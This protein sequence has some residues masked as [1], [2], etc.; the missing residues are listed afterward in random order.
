[1]FSAPH[2]QAPASTLS[3]HDALPICSNYTFTV[4]NTDCYGCH[5]AAWQSTTTLGGAVPNHVTAAFPTS[6]C[7]TCHNTNTWTSTFNHATKSGRPHNSTPVTVRASM[8][9]CTGC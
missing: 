8:L 7:S 6:Q 2:A 5:Q 9:S 4:A 1:A 3:L